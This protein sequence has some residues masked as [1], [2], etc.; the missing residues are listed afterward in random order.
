MVAQCK[1]GTKNKRSYGHYEIFPFLMTR[2]LCF[3]QP[4][5][6]MGLT[7]LERPAGGSLVLLPVVRQGWGFQKTLLDDRGSLVLSLL[8][9]WWWVR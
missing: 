2:K 5:V 6:R 1:N 4:I 8:E 7:M 9:W 3:G